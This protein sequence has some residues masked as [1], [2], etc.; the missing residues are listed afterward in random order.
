MFDLEVHVN[1]LA[2]LE[3]RPGPKKGK[4]LPSQSPI[5]WKPVVSHHSLTKHVGFP[6]SLPPLLGDQY[7]VRVTLHLAYIY[8][9]YAG[10]YSSPIGNRSYGGFVGRL[11]RCFELFFLISKGKGLSPNSQASTIYVL[12]LTVDWSKIRNMYRS[13]KKDLPVIHHASKSSSWYWWFWRW[14]IQ[15][16]FI[17]PVIDGKV[18]A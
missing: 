14:Y 18:K 13:Y 10:T 3:H 5:T 6:V 9:F 2:S 8:G 15:C 4:Q 11:S 7:V 16:N 17:H 1:F 12:L